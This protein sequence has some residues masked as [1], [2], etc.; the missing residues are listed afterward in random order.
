MRLIQNYPWAAWITI[1]LLIKWLLQMSNKVW[2]VSTNQIIMIC[3]AIVFPHVFFS[4]GKHF[5]PL[6]LK[7]HPCN[8]FG[9]FGSPGGVHES[10]IYTKKCWFLSGVIPS[11][12]FLYPKTCVKIGLLAQSPESEENGRFDGERIRRFYTTHSSRGVIF[13]VLDVF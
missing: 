2:V 3:S 11:P 10:Q 7:C 4:G 5:F 8:L 9:F 1:F 12:F 13:L 6:E